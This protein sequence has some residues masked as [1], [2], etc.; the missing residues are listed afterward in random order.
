MVIEALR[1][2]NAKM[3]L[4]NIVVECFGDK[5]C[6][7]SQYSILQ[8]K[9]ISNR[10]E[11]KSTYIPNGALYIS[12]TEYFKSTNTFYNDL[13]IAYIMSQE[14]SVDI[15]SQFDFTIAETLID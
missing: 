1:M 3:Q 4:S 5:E 2:L 6:A 8:N 11:N 15:D 12:K 7:N 9:I 10:Q 14:K 13:T